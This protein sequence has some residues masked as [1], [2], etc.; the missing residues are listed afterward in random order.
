MSKSPI[1]KWDI[2]FGLKDQNISNLFD[3]V[4]M[5]DLCKQLCKHWCF[6][7]EKGENTE[8]IHYQMRFNLIKKSRAG[9][10]LNDITSLIGEEY[11][12][13]F[14]IT[15]TNKNVTDFYSYINKAQTRIGNPHSDKQ[16]DGGQVMTTQLKDFLQKK[17][18]PYQQ[19]VVDAINNHVL[20]P[21][22]RSIYCL[23]A[24]GHIGKSSFSEYLCSH[25]KIAK[26]IQSY[27]S[28]ETLSAY[29]CSL[30]VDKHGRRCGR[31]PPAYIVD[32]PRSRN[33][34]KLYGFLSGLETIKDGSCQDP[35]YASREVYFNRP[36][37]F[38]FCNNYPP[39]D[40]ISPDRWKCYLIQKNNYELIRDPN[41]PGL[42]YEQ[43]QQQQNE[44]VMLDDTS[45][46]IIQEVETENV[47]CGYLPDKLDK[48]V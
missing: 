37:I 16:D 2:T 48:L 10:L 22:F 13:Y 47:V 15:P 44:L 34:E 3:E 25:L 5:I 20:N 31:A 32:M 11:V 6:Q 46:N 23:K 14:H 36:L 38:I 39:L 42:N 19:F 8:F 1:C 12:K 9:K 35:R 7:L 41:C 29:V 30:L 17:L 40:G 33:E 18:R 24:E 4:F 45:D 28:M 27:N 43:Q 21:D 26:K